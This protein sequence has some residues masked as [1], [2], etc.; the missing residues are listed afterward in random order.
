MGFVIILVG[1]GVV[2]GLLAT[3][4]VPWKDSSEALTAN[5]VVATMVSLL[6]GFLIFYTTGKTTMA[7]AGALLSSVAAISLWAFFKIR[8]MM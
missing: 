2:L 4:V 1:I 3:F 8:S 7:L 5:V 6:V